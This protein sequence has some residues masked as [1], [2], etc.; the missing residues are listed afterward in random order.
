[1]FHVPQLAIQQQRSCLMSDESFERVLAFNE[2]LA[3]LSATG[4]PLDLGF[5]DS[6]PLAQTLEKINNNLALQVRRGTPIDQ[7]IAEQGD[8]PPGTVP[9]SRLDRG[10]T[11][12]LRC[13]MASS[14]PLKHDTRFAAI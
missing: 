12:R 6:R 2:E 13:S 8:L 9:H 11:I 1:M 3:A 7:V 14:D 5:E 4:L 10:V